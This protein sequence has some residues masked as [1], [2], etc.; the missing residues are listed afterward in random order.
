M[1]KISKA[2]ISVSDKSN[3][4]DILKALKQHNVE[5]ISTGGTYKYI[6]DQGYDCIEIS[7]YTGSP[8]ILDGRVKTLHPKIHGGLL[9]DVDKQDQLKQMTDNQIQ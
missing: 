8:E 7:K 9:G 1:K 2:L 3:L 5:I 4:D 6:K